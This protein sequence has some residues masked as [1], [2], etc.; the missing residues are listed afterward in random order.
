MKTSHFSSNYD[1]AGRQIGEKSASHQRVHH[2]YQSNLN[3]VNSGDND[4][5]I[6]TASGSRHHQQQQH[7]Q[8]NH[9]SNSDNNSRS[10][11]INEFG[12][13]ISIKS[14][15]HSVID[16]T[17]PIIS[18]SV[19]AHDSSSNAVHQTAYGGYVDGV[20]IKYETLSGCHSEKSNDYNIVQSGSS[21]SKYQ[22]KATSKR[23]RE[24][25]KFNFIRYYIYIPSFPPARVSL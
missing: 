21:S 24:T 7:Q 5:T 15:H 16:S 23:K 6:I 11:L 1:F 2:S 4:V 14:E 18:S 12:H 10:H 8:H 3:T 25:G 20:Q 22:Q 19:V 13:P 9:H 17:S